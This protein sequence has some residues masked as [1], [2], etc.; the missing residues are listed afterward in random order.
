[1]PIPAMY[2][3]AY[4]FAVREWR[5]LMLGGHPTDAELGTLRSLVARHIN[6]TYPR[7]PADRRA[8]AVDYGVSLA[9]RDLVSPDQGGVVGVVGHV[10]EAVGDAVE[11]DVAA[12]ERAGRHA[13]GRL[14]DTV[15]GILAQILRAVRL[16]RAALP[17]KVPTDLTHAYSMLGREA[18]TLT[19]TRLAHAAQTRLR[20]RRLGR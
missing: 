2:H 20:L 19:P 12:V 6:A 10:V 7:V 15:R 5:A 3:D 18:G 14:E 17:A 13:L 8:S 16:P 9:E 4:S 11:G 1:V